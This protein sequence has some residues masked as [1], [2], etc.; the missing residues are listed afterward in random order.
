MFI[1]KVFLEPNIKQ[2]LTILKIRVVF[3][4][5]CEQISNT[6]ILRG[7]H[8]HNQDLEKVARVK[9]GKQIQS[10]KEEQ[11]YFEHV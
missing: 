3:H 7:K 5:N 8:T 2:I 4:K 1:W 6:L 9:K 10:P 11:V